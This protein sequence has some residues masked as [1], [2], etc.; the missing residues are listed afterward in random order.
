MF[1]DL[2]EQRH[3]VK[4]PGQVMLDEIRTR[5]GH[6]GLRAWSSNCPVYGCCMGAQISESDEHGPQRLRRRNRT[7]PTDGFR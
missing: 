4:R 6:E 3:A 1:A 2:V 7:V 5:P